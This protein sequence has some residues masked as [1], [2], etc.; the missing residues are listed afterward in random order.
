MIEE[1]V[2]KNKEKIKIVY[3][4]P[5]LDRGGAERFF[6]DLIK[7]LDVN[8][9]DPQLLL[10]KGGGDWGKELIDLGLEL[11]ILSKK[12]GFDLINFWQIYR[13]LKKSKAEIV[14]VQLGFYV[15]LAAYLAGVKK[16]VFTEV[17]INL[18]ETK[19]YRSLKRLIL[20]LATKIIAVSV[21]VKKDLAKRYR[22]KID[23]ISVVYNGIE[24]DNFPAQALKTEAERKARFKGSKTNFVFAT[25][26]RL[27]EQ[28]GQKYLIKAFKEAKLKNSKLIIAGEGSLRN[29]LQKLISRLKLRSQVELSGPVQAREFFQK[30]DAFILPSL[31]EGMGIVLVEAALSARPVIFF[32]IPGASEVLNKDNA[33]PVKLKNIKELAKTMAVVKDNYNE[34]ELALKVLKA[35]TEMLKRFSIKNIAKIHE[36][37]YLKLL[38]D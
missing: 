3:I 33:W 11:K 7:N 31:W 12:P 18:D 25:L 22:L 17:N 30:I 20:P 6:V 29:N 15:I 36:D 13:Y 38:N 16:I 34:P 27:E 8:K 23:N 28:K 9:F 2:L 32:D 10:Y 14:H 24:V 35:R 26:G 19:I 5:T 4:L 1:I 21:A 37:I